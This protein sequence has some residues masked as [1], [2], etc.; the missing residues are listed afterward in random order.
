LWG[1]S[2][3]AVR[4]RRAAAFGAIGGLPVGLFLLWS[5]T[6]PGAE[7]PRALDGRLEILQGLRQFGRGVAEALWSWKPIPPAVLLPDWLSEEAASGLSGGL[8]VAGA[9]AIALLLYSSLRRRYSSDQPAESRSAWL[10]IRVLGLFV[11]VYLAFFALAFLAT[12]PTPDVDSRTLLP[13]LPALLGLVVGLALLRPG[14]WRASTALPVGW[15][16][17]LLAALAGYAVISQD[18]VLGLHR[19]GLGYT[20]R[21]WRASPTVQALR[22]IPPQRILVS[23]EPAA[24]LLLTGRMPYSIPEIAQRRSVS[25]FATYGSGT[26]EAELA[27][28]QGRAWLVLFSSIHDQFGSLYGDR[29]AERLE[30]FTRGLSLVNETADGAIYAFPLQGR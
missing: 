25:D 22:A 10:L 11:V 20:S 4:L 6:L 23:N 15:T 29:A 16:A 26:T 19:T 18:I 17:L 5:A 13:L 8:A 21:E 1:V 3:L 30:A 24:V 12:D 27:F 14:S 9:L 2:T 7:G 28:R